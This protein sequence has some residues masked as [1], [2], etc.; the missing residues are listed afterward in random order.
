MIDKFISRVIIITIKAKV[1]P[2]TIGN[3]RNA[4]L[5]QSAGSRFTIGNTAS[6]EKNETHEKDNV[7]EKIQNSII[8]CPTHF[9]RQEAGFTNQGPTYC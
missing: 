5:L 7:R 8:D 2:F 9:T 6:D 4:N 1:S 3:T